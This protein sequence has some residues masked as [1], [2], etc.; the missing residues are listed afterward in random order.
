MHYNYCLRYSESNNN[1]L[2]IIE[3][4]YIMMILI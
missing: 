1:Y 3:T 2:L 4:A